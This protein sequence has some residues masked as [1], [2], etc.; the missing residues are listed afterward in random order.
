LFPPPCV[1]KEGRSKGDKQT[2][3]NTRQNKTQQAKTSTL[4][5]SNDKQNVQHRKISTKTAKIIKY[6]CTCVPYYIG[7]RKFE[8][9]IDRRT[10]EKH[11]KSM[12]KQNNRVLKEKLRKMLVLTL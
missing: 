9:N 2:Q 4:I 8:K 10:G 3:V 1:D 5:K 6:T 7:K 12:E 11:E